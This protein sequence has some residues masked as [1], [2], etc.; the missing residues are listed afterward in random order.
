[1]GFFKYLIII[2]FQIIIS[3]VTVFVLLVLIEDFYNIKDIP[4]IDSISLANTFMVFVTFVVVVATVT[5][6][7]AGIY[8]TYWF[9]KQKEAI[10]RENMDEVIDALLEKKDM[11]D[12]ILKVILSQPIISTLMKN[13]I[14]ELTK[15]QKDAFEKEIRDKSKQ[16][17]IKL[18]DMKSN[19]LTILENKSKEVHQV[20][21]LNKLFGGK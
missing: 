21:E 10:L 5:I 1:M 7:S 2:V 15:L 20:D 8:F 14:E 3:I 12:D 4:N 11:K 18:E 6:T 9:S 16:L 17:D 13:R 19:V